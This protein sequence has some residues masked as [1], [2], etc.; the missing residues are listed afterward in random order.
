MREKLNVLSFIL[1]ETGVG[2]PLGVIY[3]NIV[4]ATVSAVGE[5][6]R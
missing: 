6:I 3:L 1:M 2:R 5:C 4:V